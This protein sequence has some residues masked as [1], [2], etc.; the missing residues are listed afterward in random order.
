MRDLQSGLQCVL[1]IRAGWKNAIS[2]TDLR[3]V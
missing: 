1:S 3:Y 2:D